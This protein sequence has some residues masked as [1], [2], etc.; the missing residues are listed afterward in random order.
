M[1]PEI[2]T[3]LCARLRTVAKHLHKIF[4]ELGVERRGA[5]ADRARALS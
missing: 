1:N 5:A 3:F 4:A 2:G